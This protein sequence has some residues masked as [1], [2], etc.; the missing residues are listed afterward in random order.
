MMSY[1]STTTT[2]VSVA[3]EEILSNIEQD[4]IPLL[5]ELFD[6]FSYKIL[7]SV[8]DKPKTVFQICD[9]NH[10]PVSSTYKKIKKL[11]NMGLLVV[12]SII[13]NEKGKKVI[14]YKSKIRSIELVLDKQNVI[15]QLKK[16]VNGYTNKQ[17]VIA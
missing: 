1:T 3:E 6:G 11:R 13:I 5:K 15:L 9:E 4:A 17:Q 10:V 8:M 7:L 16:N 14:F 12:D 2:A